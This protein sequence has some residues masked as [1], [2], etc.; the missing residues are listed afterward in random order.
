MTSR[1]TKAVLLTMGILCPGSI[2]L[3]L[4]YTSATTFVLSPWISLAVHSVLIFMYVLTCFLAP[5]RVQVSNT[6]PY[7]IHL[8]KLFLNGS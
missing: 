2:F 5:T 4:V 8:I 1:L 6:M 3:A 7:A